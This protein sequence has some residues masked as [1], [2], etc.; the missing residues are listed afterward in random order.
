MTF[1][2]WAAAHRR[3]LLFLLAV[4]ALVGAVLMFRLP[5]S[6]F[7]TVDFPRVVVSLDAGDRPAAQMEAAV[8][9]PMEQAIRRVPAVANVR[10]TTSRGSAE[11]SVSFAWGT[12][13]A[14]A[15]LQVNAAT[16][17]IIP[18]LPAGT[19]VST[20]R[21]DPTVFPIIAY[22]LTS[23][24]VSL[25]T[26]RSV[27][28][29]QVAP[30]L[31][32]IAGVAR[33]DAI[34]GAVDEIH[35]VV[36][37]ARLQALGLTLDD[38]SKSLAAG[39]VITAT[40]KL[41]DRYK[42]L[43][44]L[45][46]ASLKT[47]EDVGQVIVAH[48]S[49]GVVRLRDVATI[50]P[51]AVPEWIR[52]TADG[53]DA[54]LISIYQQ[55]GSNSVQIAADVRQ[56]FA[57]MKP[58]L[59]PG[60][61]LASWYDQSDLVMASA[62]SV[63]DAILIGALLAAGVLLVFLRSLKVTLIAVVVV[64][65]VLAVTVLLL[66]LLNMSFNV[67]TLGGMAAAVGLIIDDAIVMTEHIVRRLREQ[68]DAAQAGA[69]V[70]HAATEFL[71]PLAASSAATLVIFAP[72][73]FLT[74]V[75]GAFFKA[76]SITMAGGLFISFIVTAVG[77]PL[78]A[79]LFLGEKEARHDDGGRFTERLRVAYGRLMTRLL[80]RP[81]WALAAVIPMAL[82]G[83][84]AFTQ[85]GS[86]FM[87]SIDEG[88]FVLDY[89]SAPGTALSETDRLL[90]QVEKIISASPDVQTFSRRTGTGLGGGLSEANSGDF[91][92]R[93]KSVGRRPVGVVMD[94]I[95]TRVE[96]QVPG[97]SIEM[98]QLMEDL[99]GDLTA[100][101]QPVEVK[102]FSDNE[103]LLE[104]TA[105][106][107][108][109]RL[110]KIQGVVDVRNGINPAGD[111]L[112]LHI[113]RVKA[114]LEGVDP[115]TVA[116]TTAD[117]LTGT[118]AT[119]MLMGVKTV[120]VRVMLPG[121]NRLHADQVAQLPVRA[122]DGHVFPL[123]RVT[124]LETV[125]GQPE[126]GKEDLKRMIAV[127]ARIDQRDLGSVMA[128]VKTM[129]G[130]AGVLPG[131][132]HVQYGGLYAQQQIA[133][134]GLLKVFAA[135]AALVFLLL[136]FIYERFS[137]AIAIVATSLLSVSAVFIGLWLTGIELNI[138]AMMGMTM[139]IG[140]VTEVGIFY[141]SE[142]QEVEEGRTLSESLVLAGQNRMRPITMTTLA[143]I[144]TLLP[145]AFA[146]GQGSEMQQPLAVAIISGL[147]VQLPLV[148]LAMPAFYA[149]M[150]RSD[151]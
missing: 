40:G 10:S 86:G 22:S 81:L 85:V 115:A 15:T 14:L 9:R 18:Q 43:L 24:T 2:D 62:A 30:R 94:D 129:L 29:Y 27:A 58:Q 119:Q 95:R 93:L 36:D 61:T 109:G 128:D 108:A 88:G 35:A 106:D 63:R 7:P 26:L 127:T 79:D 144:L 3:S 87:P 98:A 148:L 28:D 145:L 72:L 13:M 138:T 76:L 134:A 39:N 130:A 124:T 139:V 25:A 4:A 69:T 38:V 60:I 53:Q 151:A 82:L 107:V 46:D 75:T 32:G 66:S 133:F 57:A 16:A 83:G 44:V 6:L 37:T 96:H 70:R 118:V 147:V 110:A 125:T 89:R 136:L 67:M 73:A 31:A 65:T 12:D 5:S 105:V 120:G 49:T 104:K 126:I 20:R 45:A 54:V 149:A 55:P 59:P 19:L 77:V 92:I 8:T 140:I 132:V 114:A 17:Q 50:L 150:R 102:L 74:G 21:M 51:G 111:A 117:A 33:A 97:L 143:A 90:R 11:I 137:V 121:T 116:Q 146:I 101:P 142:Q 41:E 34:G 122:S 64:P 123:G 71:R 131:G 56:A 91:F 84:F 99:I 135:A 78:L 80:A 141:F 23:K 48:G 112:V 52:V 1:I 100:V 113:D 68:R 103:P 47:A 42:L